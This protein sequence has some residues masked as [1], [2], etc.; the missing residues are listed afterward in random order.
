M[1]RRRPVAKLRAPLAM[2]R[3]WR[4]RPARC[5]STACADTTSWISSVCSSGISWSSLT[6][7]SRNRRLIDDSGYPIRLEVDGGVKIDNI[8]LIAEAGA[9]TFVAGSAIF[10]PGDY[11]GTI[12]A[13]REAIAAATA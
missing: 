7:T 6:S 3:T 12:T 8:R 9:D 11:A 10:G 4:L 1:R 13:M 5:V 2:S